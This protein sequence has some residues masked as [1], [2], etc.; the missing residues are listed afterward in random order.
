MNS[1][2][3]ITSCSARIRSL[4]EPFGFKTIGSFYKFLKQA[5]PHTRLH[6]GITY[7]RVAKALRYV[8]E[9]LSN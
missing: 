3:R 4:A 9:E 1:L 5:K 7:I 6:F 2:T 8:E